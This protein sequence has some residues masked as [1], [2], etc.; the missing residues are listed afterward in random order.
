[1]IVSAYKYCQELAVSLI[2]SFVLGASVISLKDH[3]CSLFEHHEYS[4][5]AGPNEHELVYL[6]STRNHH[7]PFTVLPTATEGTK[8][9]SDLDESS[10]LFLVSA[11]VL[12]A[13]NTRLIPPMFRRLSDTRQCII[14]LV[15]L[16][17]GSLDQLH[18]ACAP[19]GYSVSLAS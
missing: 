15:S 8:I 10:K 17:T 5:A 4:G 16:L 19:G 12:S 6:V 9:F 13:I 2:A 14:N 3:E 18:Q 7:E 11:A 1:M